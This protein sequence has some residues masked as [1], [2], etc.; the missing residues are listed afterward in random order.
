ML[1][2]A[3]LAYNGARILNDS[4]R[5]ALAVLDNFDQAAPWLGLA[6]LATFV[7]AWQEPR[8]PHISPRSSGAALLSFCRAHWVEVALFAVILAF[9]IF[10]R[11]YRFGDTL[12]PADGL[13][14]EEHINGSVAYRALEGDRPLLFPLVRWGS[15][16][17]FLLFGENTLGLRFFFPVMSIATLIA[18]YFLLRQLVSV[19]AAL[20]GLA[21]YAAAWWPSLRSSLT[22]EGTIYSVTFAFFLVRGLKKRSPFMFLGAGVLAGLMSYE[23]EP[24]RVVPMIAAGFVGAAAAREVL[25]RRPFRLSA[26]KDRAVVLL[27]AAWRPALIFLMAAGIVLVPMIIGTHRGQDLYLTSVHR[28]ERTRGGEL[29]ADDWQDQVKWTAEIFLPVGPQEYPTSPPRDVPG[30]R[31]LD[32]VAGWLTLAGLLAGTAF[33]FRGFRLLFVSWM[34]VSLSAGAL[35]LQ[36]FAAWKFFG[37]VP[38]ALALAALLVDGVRTRV[39]AGFGR[40]GA[41][42]LG[43]ILVIGA[44]FSFWWNADTLFNEVEAKVQQRYGGDASLLYNFCDSLRERG[45]DNYTYAF[46]SVESIAGFAGSRDTI[47]Q[48]KRAWGD[49]IWVCHDLQGA[50]LPAPEEAWPLQGVPAGPVTLAFADPLGPTEELI[51]ELNRA[52]P[53]LGQPDREEHGPADSFTLINYEFASGEELARYGLWADY[54]QAG[55]DSPAVSRIDPV[56]D[57]SWDEEETPLAPPFSVRWRGVV[58]VAEADTSGLQAVTDEPVEVRLDGQVIYSTRGGETQETFVELVPGWHPV[59]ITLDKQHDGGTFALAWKAAAS[60]VQRVVEPDDLFPL[61]ELDGWLHQRSLGYTGDRHQIV[62]QRLDF[63]PHYASAEVLRLQAQNGVSGPFLTEERW[64]GV[65]EV[66]EAGD[67]FLAAEFG[68]GTLT[69]LVD[70]VTVATDDTPFQLLRKLRADVT[71]DEGRHTLEIVQQFERASS[72]CGTIL[73]VQRRSEPVEGGEPKLEDVAIQVTPY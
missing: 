47:E 8:L 46:S 41:L 55:N 5:R 62:T 29:L 65:W 10:M 57:L 17:G 49:L 7:A 72:R 36:D 45:K 19:P 68:A 66:D 3:A 39:V 20:F 70:G 56:Q 61:A 35:H 43:G 22:A 24:F 50:A 48:Q 23:Y 69:L 33:L 26:A 53:R 67:Y 73:S 28:G 42:V 59:E 71:L 11:V 38:V 37:L 54:F 58:Y 63:A 15:A 18:F 52:Y 1:A 30:T 27:R 64:S 40:P 34:V 51:D 4:P 32:P 44:A 6:L 2:A 16:A 25:L 21:L 60:G 9:G 12:P 14:C 13:C 31:L